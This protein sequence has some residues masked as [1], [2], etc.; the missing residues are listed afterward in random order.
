MV[1]TSREFIL[2]SDTPAI[3]LIV[4]CTIAQHKCEKKIVSL[5]R[6]V[7]NAHLLLQLFVQIDR[8][9]NREF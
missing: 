5:V 7:P 6:H 2:H 1:S 8:V 9:T 3:A 4:I